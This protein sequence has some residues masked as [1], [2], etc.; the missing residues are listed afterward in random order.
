VL[1]ATQY[2]AVVRQPEAVEA[3]LASTWKDHDCAGW[4][5]LLADDW[6]ATHIDAQ[7]IKKDQALEVCRTGPPIASAVR[8][9]GG[10]FLRI[11]GTSPQTPP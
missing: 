2:A 8:S 7:V 4:S 9:I 11:F 1:Q 3:Q 6:T 5:A 10:P